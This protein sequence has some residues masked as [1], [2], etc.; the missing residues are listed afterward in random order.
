[1]SNADPAEI[2][3]RYVEHQVHAGEQQFA[4][5]EKQTT[6]PL[7][8]GWL[9][10][11]GH[12]VKNWK[13]RYF[14]LSAAPAHVSQRRSLVLTYFDS[15][16]EAERGACKGAVPL[17]PGDFEVLTEH[18]KQY[19]NEDTIMICLHT[20]SSNAHQ[21]YL[22]RADS[23]PGAM[24]EWVE[25]IQRGGAGPTAGDDT[26]RRVQ[27]AAHWRVSLEGKRR[28][29]KGSNITDSI[30]WRRSPDWNDRVVHSQE[31]SSLH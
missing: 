12:V 18:G 26:P 2:Y 5:E 9:T 8:S 7:K 13:R 23:D 27:G 24:R 14:V 4:E 10:K 6:L 16:E 25:L 3:Q 30:A 15:P 20:V 11:Q 28:K 19:N 31:D 29:R 22:I 17:E 21:S 1:M